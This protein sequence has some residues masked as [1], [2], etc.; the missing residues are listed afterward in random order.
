MSVPTFSAPKYELAEVIHR[1]KDQLSGKLSAYQQLALSAIERCRTAALGGH[2]DECDACGHLCISYNS[3]LC[4][5]GYVAIATV[6]N[7]RA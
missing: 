2:I 4:G 3:P 7:V 1:F 6:P 5:A